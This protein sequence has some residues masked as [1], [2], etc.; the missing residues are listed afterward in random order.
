MV[1]R[2][3]TCRLTLRPT[4]LILTLVLAGCGSSPT[5]P[6]NPRPLPLPD[7]TVSDDIPGGQKI[8]VP[9]RPVTFT[10]MRNGGTPPFEFQWRINNI[11]LRDWDPATVFV[12]DGLTLDGRP[13]VS[14]R[15]T[16]VVTSRTQGN[17]QLATAA[18][19]NFSIQYP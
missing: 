6:S 2:T 4:Y 18:L 15:H 14:G 12:W 3:K 9:P 16:L 5:A 1:M 17:T 13:T 10:A 8:L 11:L 19:L 7:L